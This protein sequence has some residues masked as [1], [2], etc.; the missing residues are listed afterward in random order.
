MRVLVVPSWYPNAEDP[1]SGTF[2]REQALLVADRHEVAV[3]YG[4]EPGI[5][6]RGR[7]EVGFEVQDGLPTVRVR[8]GPPRRGRFPFVLGGLGAGLARLRREG[9]APDVIHA[10]VYE[11]GAFAALLAPR[12][13]LVVSEHF[14]AVARGR[15]GR[16]DLVLARFGYARADL[17]APVSAG[18]AKRLAELGVR[19]PIRVVPNAVNTDRFH[20]PATHERADGEE[21]LLLVGGLVPIKG[22]PVALEAVA[23]LQSSH[24][25]AVLEIVGD[26]PE[27]A[28]LQT[29]AMRLGIADAV[30]FSGRLDRD[31][32]AE[33]M[34]AA[35]VL[36]SA[37]EWENL[38]GVQVEALASGLPVVATRVGG[39]P[40]VVDDDVG[41]LVS[42]GDP[43]ALAEAL[44]ATLERRDLDPGRLAA[45]ARERFGQ[46]RVAAL[47]DEIYSELA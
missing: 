17:V 37:S 26:G 21:R 10:H 20:P 9:F 3:L 24:P 45:R 32:V 43:S 39:V 5:P 11:S 28:A 36:V 19:T 8:V 12:T 7:W 47:W 44:A 22:V 40:D 42:P 34:R 33:R 18:L 2:V 41:A 27:R 6:R 30:R 25:R 46:E 31:A 38:P 23:R 29:L 4:F 1:T 13:Q 35:D 16:I 15:L 14:S